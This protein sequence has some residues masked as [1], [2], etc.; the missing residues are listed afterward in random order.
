MKQDSSFVPSFNV[1]S[2]MLLPLLEHPSTKADL[3]GKVNVSYARFK[4]HLDWA[5]KRRI[6]QLTLEKGKVIVELTKCGREAALLF[7]GNG[8]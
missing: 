1:L 8:K 4:K 3:A 7:F 2:Q 5:E 6:V